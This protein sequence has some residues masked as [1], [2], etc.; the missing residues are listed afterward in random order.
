MGSAKADVHYGVRY[1]GLNIRVDIWTE[2]LDLGGSQEVDGN[3]Y[4]DGDRELSG[5]S[6]ESTGAKNREA[7][8][9]N[10]QSINIQEGY[11]LYI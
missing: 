9:R 1:T 10:T 3:W 2:Y 6:G 8:D 11:S 7:E 4:S 5:G